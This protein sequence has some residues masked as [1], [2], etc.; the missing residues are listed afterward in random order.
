VHTTGNDKNRVTA[1]IGVTASNELL[2]LFTVLKG[3]KIP[4]EVQALEDGDLFVV[5]NSSAW[6]TEETFMIWIQ[7]IWRPHASQSPRSLLIL[8]RFRVHMK[9]SVLNQFNDLNTDV[10]F[11]PP[12]LTFYVQPCDVYI[13]KGLKERVRMSWVE[14]MASQITETTPGNLFSLLF[15]CYS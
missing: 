7:K 2:P 12:G 4:R 8:D 3:K 14:F 15:I 9:Q 6:I 5:S 11:V 13:N 1:L 10:L